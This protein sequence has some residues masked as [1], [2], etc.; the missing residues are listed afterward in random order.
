MLKECA[1]S[2]EPTSQ[3]THAK[4]AFESRLRFYLPIPL[5]MAE[6]WSNWHRTAFTPNHWNLL[7]SKMVSIKISGLLAEW[8]QC[9]EVTFKSPP[10]PVSSPDCVCVCARACVSYSF[11]A[12]LGFTGVWTAGRGAL[13]GQNDAEMDRKPPLEFLKLI[14]SHPHFSALPPFQSLTHPPTPSPIFRLFF[15]LTLSSS[16]ASLCFCSLGCQTVQVLLH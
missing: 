16:S 11:Q 5:K 4:K 1:A 9:L 6:K 10:P 13:I 3:N 7:P 2:S 8:G 12:L 15:F 14:F